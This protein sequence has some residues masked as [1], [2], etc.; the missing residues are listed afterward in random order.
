MKITETLYVT[1]RD[2]WRSWLEE[3]HDSKGEIWLIYY[4]KH[5]GKPRI[6]Y[7]DAVE[8]AICFGWIDSIIQK[9][10][11]E[12][13]AQKFTPRMNT[14]NWS[15]ANKKRIKKM[16]S[17]DKMTAAGL[18][19]IHNSV[20]LEV[21]ESKPE[22]DMPTE[23]AEALDAN[24]KARE[25]FNSLAPSYRKQ[26]IGWIS[27]GKREDTLRQRVEEAI[28]LLEQNKKLGMK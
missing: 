24:D 25:F 11:E 26:Y 22:P 2:D 14:R 5:S 13:F 3:N 9:I 6:P 8:E 1:N 4:K 17:M 21:S 7:D 15:D 27:S 20:D 19:K 12:K 10:D 28:E 23:F 18:A 16:L